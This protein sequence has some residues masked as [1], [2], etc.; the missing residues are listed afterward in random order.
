MKQSSR[1]MKETK[2]CATSFDTIVKTTTTAKV[3]AAH[4]RDSSHGTPPS[5]PFKAYPDSLATVQLL[6]SNGVVTP[7]TRSQ[8]RVPFDASPLPSVSAARPRRWCFHHLS[9]HLPAS[10]HI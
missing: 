8:D 10:T 6:A 5:S 7:P 4:Y 9:L 1:R 2:P 3:S